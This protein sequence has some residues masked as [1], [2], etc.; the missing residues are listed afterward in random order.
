MEIHPC[1]IISRW[2][3]QLIVIQATV[4][5]LLLPELLS[6]RVQTAPLLFYCTVESRL[7]FCG[8]RVNPKLCAV[9]I[10]LALKVYTFCMPCNIYIRIIYTSDR[11]YGLVIRV[12]DC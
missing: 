7:S 8:R 2:P 6:F 11:L 3:S 4:L 12:P 5:L 1:Q 9:G 10:T